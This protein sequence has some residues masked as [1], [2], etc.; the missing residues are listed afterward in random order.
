MICHLG[1]NGRDGGLSKYQ[2]HINSLIKYCKEH[3]IRLA[4]AV[5]P[6]TKGRQNAALRDWLRSLK[7]VHLIRFDKALSVNNDGET[8]DYEKLYITVGAHPNEAGN[9]VMYQ[10][11]RKD[12][13]ELFQ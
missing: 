1:T 3:Q 9:E 10:Q 4:L 12:V 13:P 7:E 6:S 5:F 11:V 2:E 8:I